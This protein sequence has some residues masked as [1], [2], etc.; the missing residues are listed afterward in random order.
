MVGK[1]AIT[2]FAG[3]TGRSFH[4]AVTLVACAALIKK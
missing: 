2:S 1:P 3:T 4:K